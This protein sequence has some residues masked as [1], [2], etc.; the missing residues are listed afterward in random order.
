[1]THASC[2]AP[3]LTHRGASTP[4]TSLKQTEKAEL[5]TKMMQCEVV[6][7]S[8][9]LDCGGTGICRITGTNSIKPLLANKNC[10]QT[11]GQISISA[12]GKI[13]MFFYRPYLCIHLYRQHFHKGVFTVMEPCAIPTDIAASFNSSLG[14]IM[15]GRYT[16]TEKDGY[17]RVDL[18][19]K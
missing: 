19:G 2:A 13:S 17:F 14:T 9:S 6:F 11:L 3:S 18:N 15:P 8:P 4:I 16:V 7:G 10:R 12:E 5:P 1:M